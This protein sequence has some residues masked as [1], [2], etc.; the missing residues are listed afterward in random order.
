MKEQARNKRNNH[1]VT[2][3][4]HTMTLSECVE[5]YSISKSTIRWR[6]QHNRDIITGARM[7]GERRDSE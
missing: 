2:V 4:G 3:D 5:Q 6:E 1:R 7:D